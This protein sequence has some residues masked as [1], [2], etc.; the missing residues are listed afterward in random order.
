MP[1]VNIPEIGA[2][3]FPDTMSIP[4]INR[5]IREEVIP[6]FRRQ[7]G[8]AQAEPAG[9]QQLPVPERGFFG[10]VGARAG[11]VA[12]SL[13]SGA[14]SGVSGLGGLA[15][16]ATGG[17][18]N[19]LSRAGRGILEYGESLMSPEL[20]NKRAAFAQA[21]SQAEAQGFRAEVAAVARELASNPG[22]L[23]SMAIEQIPQF[24]ASFGIG[25]GAVAIGQRVGA[26]GARASVVGAETAAA[27]AGRRA[28]IGAAIGTSAGL[29]GGD[30]AGQTYEDV[31]KLPV[32]TMQQSPAYRELLATMSPQEARESL[33]TRAA[34][35]A[36]VMAG[37]FSAATTALLPS[38]EAAAFS[39][40]LSRNA[41]S[42]ALRVGTGEATGEFIEEGG[43]QAAQNLAASRADTERDLMRGVGGAATTGA[44]LGGAMG[45]GVGAISAPPVDPEEAR[46][47]ELR[48]A[49]G[50]VVGA[51]EPAP[52]API[53]LP[54]EQRDIETPVG[55]LSRSQLI[56]YMD[57]T[58]PSLI[59]EKTKA[60]PE[61]GR[62]AD[63][64]L[65]RRLEFQIS[66]ADENG[67]LA[68]FQELLA[69]REQGRF[70]GLMA[71]SP[72]NVEAFRLAEIQ[73]RLERKPFSVQEVRR[74]LAAAEQQVEQLI[75]ARQDAQSR[76]SSTNLVAR[77]AVQAE[78]DQLDQLIAG[79]E[80][81][82]RQLENSIPETERENVARQN[83]NEA[84]IESFD[85]TQGR[86]E[87][88]FEQKNAEGI[89]VPSAEGMV[90][91]PAQQDDT[92]A[93]AA[94]LTDM[95]YVL[96]PI[97]E[98]DGSLVGGEAVV[99]IMP[100]D[101][102]GSGKVVA[103]V[104]REIE[105]N[106]FSVPVETT[107]D[108]LVQV[109]IRETARRTQESA[110]RRVG[111]EQVA[112]VRAGSAIDPK[113]LSLSPRRSV[114]RQG[115][116]Q[117]GETMFSARRMAG[118]PETETE[119]AQEQA[120]PNTDKSL[121][122]I[123]KY[124]ADLR[125]K[126]KQGR[127][128]ANSLE[129]L[130][131]DRRFNADQIY[132]AFTIDNAIL[133]TIPK[134]AAYRFN[135]LED[136]IVDNAEAAKATGAK[137][138]DRAQARVIKPT[139]SLPGFIEISLAEDMLPILNETAAHEAFHVLQDYFGA[140]DKGFDKLLA[141][142]FEDGMT[143]DQL[144][145]SIKRR[146]QGLKAPNSDKSYWT[147]LKEGIGDNPL[148]VRE[149]Q[150]YA[151]GSLTDAAMRGQKV[152]G[153]TAPFQR[154][155]NFLRDTF[156]RLRSGLNGDGYYTA[157][158]L[159]AG[160]GARA[161]GFTQ[162][163]PTDGGTEY[164]G[165]DI[166][167]GA[168]GLPQGYKL[169]DVTQKRTTRLVDG[170][171]I[172]N[173]VPEFVVIGQ[174]GMSVSNGSTPEEAIQKFYE[175]EAKRERQK[176]PA[177]DI[178]GSFPVSETARRGPDVSGF[179]RSV[180]EI[181]NAIKG[182]KLS[183]ARERESKCY[184]Y[185]GNAAIETGNDYVIGNVSGANGKRIP[186]A[187]VRDS[188]GR[189]YDPQFDAWF[190]AEAY[191]DAV[192]GFEPTIVM[193]GAEVS[194]FGRETGKYPSPTMIA[195]QQKK[196]STEFSARKAPSYSAQKPT[197]PPGTAK[198][199]Q[200]FF[201][202]VKSD[203]NKPSVL[204]SVLAK[205]LDKKK[206][207]TAGQAFVRT[208]I[209]RSGTL[210]NLHEMEKAKG[211]TGRSAAVAMELSLQ[212][213]ARIEQMISS[214]MGKYDPKT[215]KISRR[216]DVKPLFEIIKGAK[217]KDQ[218][219][220]DTLQVYLAALRERDERK[221][222]R[223]G[224]V[225][226]T[227]SEVNA[228]I[229]EYESTRPEWKNVAKELDKVNDALIDWSVATGVVTPEQ[230]KNLRAV[231]YTPFYR[232]MDKDSIEDPTRSISPR[233]SDSFRSVV[234]AIN[235]EMKGGEKPLGDL[236]ENIIRNADSIM[237][238][239]LKNQA[240]KLA[241]ETMQFANLGRKVPN[242]D[243]DSTITYKVD[244][245]EVT[246]EVDDAALFAAL[247]GMPRNIQNGIYNT[248]AQVASFV[249]T[250]ITSA[251][252]FMLSSL[253]RGK[254]SAMVQE[255]QPF[256]TNTFAGL[257][258]AYKG[259]EELKNFKMQTGF[260]AMEFG[261]GEKNMAKVF[262]RKLND[263]GILNALRKGKAWNAIEL[264]FDRLQEASEA[265]E[266]AER[267]KLVENLMKRGVS[268]EEAQFQAYLLAP[269]S[270]RGTGQGYVGATL[271]WLMPLVPFLNAKLQTTYRLFE[272]EKG[273]KQDYKMLWIPRQIFLRG[274]I[275]TA[276][277]VA[278]YLANIADGEDEWDEIPAHMKLNYD[279]IP[280]AGM[281][282]TLPRA[283]EIGQ[284][285]GALPVF[286]LDAIRRG[287]GKDLANAVAEVGINTF[288]M[289]PT[290]KALDPIF[291]VLT[292][293][294]F[295]RWQHLENMSQQGLPV[296]ERVNRSTTS[297][298]KL[299]AGVVN[300]V[301]GTDVLSPIRA[302]ALLNGY[303]GSLGVAFMTGI[304]SALSLGGLAPERPTGPFGGLTPI[305]SA[306]GLD[307]FVRDPDSMPSRF[308]GDFYK[309]K[310]MTDQLARSLS[311]ARRNQDFSRLEE[312][313]GEAGLPLRLRTTINSA[314]DQI[315]ELNRR[316]T[317][318]EQSMDRSGSEKTEAIQ[319]L[320][321]RRDV[322]AKR[323]VDQARSIGAF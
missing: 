226:A 149:A 183:S 92:R 182:G 289:N 224:F 255:G 256:M 216:T 313:R 242:K 120:A 210:H 7:Q 69:D 55:N 51:R 104:E 193:S 192:G 203:I 323:V 231:F 209:N 278:A 308:V 25:R 125:G 199:A 301:S 143:L 144:E 153:L 49:I 214:G 37:G 204:D 207:E 36:G 264:T 281:Q 225:D 138:G 126:G 188:G 195:D 146:L 16:M 306:V 208:A 62:E 174:Y 140:F 115:R 320:I 108:K 300:T 73:Q 63:P 32:E 110:E 109:P 1:V 154:F 169:R 291:S 2:V 28:G 123:R 89:Q 261:M 166:S 5:A 100:S 237:K 8:V 12:G 52:E 33:A 158:D 3:N 60:D 299:V 239:G 94:Q 187:V 76:L 290:P 57:R 276:F 241:A 75:S 6:N 102:P 298:G 95:R 150:A 139:A 268:Q 189:I 258:D 142:S 134:D 251:P 286:L 167:A 293:F 305:T 87:R 318:I 200:N 238:A 163:A 86:R 282:I 232:L 202:R 218:K 70:R 74:D 303:T 53:A 18:D 160:A 72:E 315:S 88:L 96:N 217:L 240:M 148:S 304:D 82:R 157:A 254:I 127:L 312:L 117:G 15:G 270:R 40:N 316:I 130:L 118:E 78:I 131:N 9:P 310:E 319:P 229:R 34:R 151:F 194:A 314:S 71:N 38:V 211:Y 141:K 317:Q 175:G 161:E 236:F 179:Y 98:S 176:L 91:I 64:E 235:K 280:I 248:M 137:V 184:G 29:Q 56:R 296:A 30:I 93:G 20:Q 77:E 170:T 129:K 249:R 80:Q 113:G 265:T 90:T 223:R 205:L 31:M 252:S 247:A 220:V 201:E 173:S 311:N 58:L 172:D 81:I 17:F 122:I 114:D 233:V 266:M 215:G 19:P 162:A 99:D 21:L 133:K 273:D 59:E 271:Q 135:F 165:R 66:R 185:S 105:G 285:F 191:S 103:F 245:K 279:I 253:W 295:F 198:S 116:P 307:R 136:I 156:S 246:F 48:G 283:F 42:R 121:A 68:I 14:G 67:K 292:N 222:G 159:L 43:G 186:H 50:D 119:A 212:N 145:P 244:G 23:A 101:E 274:L 230:A 54:R 177:T 309:I 111:P 97:R 190:D 112:G 181:E 128:L 22:L 277:S 213:S 180:D 4:E 46:R 267:I 10:T 178:R 206:G 219:D 45:A 132:A 288:W 269:Y 197:A 124:L 83:M 147:V 250:S 284:F 321:Q 262:K 221:R 44:I 24:L 297:V 302:Q 79:R 294:D 234:S 41:I 322:I 164:S 228:A 155:V 11:D 168:E 47:A 85:I 227:D 257:R 263:E 171:E 84:A 243:P 35:E 260:G 65:K 39:K 152:T 13:V 26:T 272:N 106:I 275:V 107:M 61:V 287:E 196:S 27:E 259:S